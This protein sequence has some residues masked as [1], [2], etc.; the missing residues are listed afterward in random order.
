M[1][2]RPESIFLGLP[3]VVALIVVLVGAVGSFGLMLYAARH[4]KSLLLI[5]LFTGWVLAPFVALAWAYVVSKRWGV[6]T[7]KTLYGITLL[8]T[9]GSLAVYGNLVLGTLR[10]KNGFIFLVVPAGTWLLIAIAFA[11]TALTSRRNTDPRL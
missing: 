11:L 10:A 4:Q 5:A 8:I 3:R 6:R 2:G 9:A 1:T 7:Q